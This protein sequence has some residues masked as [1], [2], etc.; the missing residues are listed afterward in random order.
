MHTATEPAS[1][2]RSDNTSRSCTSLR[3]STT[4][5]RQQLIKLPVANLPRF[6]GNH[7]RW[8]SFKNTFLSLIHSHTD[9]DDLNKFLYLRD[10]LEGSAFNKTALYDANADNYNKA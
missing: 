10:C 9:L 8:L 2:S 1:S 7:D 5:E 3:N 4:I 6:D